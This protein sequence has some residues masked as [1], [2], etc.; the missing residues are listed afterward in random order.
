MS[1]SSL[2]A[3]RRLLEP[4]IEGRDDEECVFRVRTALQ[5]LEAVETDLSDRQ[6]DLENLEAALEDDA[7]L[8]ERIVEAGVIDRAETGEN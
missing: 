2:G 6:I 5:L 3:V 4:L 1:E 7:E 8:R